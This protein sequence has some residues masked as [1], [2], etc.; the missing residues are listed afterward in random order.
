MGAVLSQEIAGGL[1]LSSIQYVPVGDGGFRCTIVASVNDESRHI[2]LVVM[3]VEKDSGPLLDGD[4]DFQ[5]NDALVANLL[6]FGV[7]EYAYR[8]G[9]HAD[10]RK[11]F[12]KAADRHSRAAVQLAE[13]VILGWYQTRLGWCSCCFERT[14]HRGVDGTFLPPVWLCGN[15]GAAT[16][17][18]FAAGCRHMARRPHGPIRVSPYCAE[19]R[20]E[21]R[22]FA[23][24]SERYRDLDA[25]D[26]LHKYDKKNLAGI[27]RT[28]LVAGAG[29]VVIGPIVFF[30]A[31][32]IGGALA[33]SGLIGP[34]LSGAAAT[35]H[36]LAVLGGGSIAAGGFGVA[37]GTVVVTATG[38]AL[39]GTLGAVTASAYLEDD[40]SFRIEKLKDG[41][42][43]PVVLAS[44]F[45]TE[46]GSGW[47]PWEPIITARYANNPVYRVHWG[48]KELKALGVAAGAIGGKAAAGVF[49]KG[50]AMHA[51][52][53]G[54]KLVPALGAATLA[55]DAIANPWHVARSRAEQT[56][57]VLADLLA[58]VDT[59][60]FILVGHSLG[61]R[62]ML[63]TAELLATK[64]GTPRLEA[65]HLLG[66]AV[67]TGGD[68]KLLNASVTERVWNYHSRKDSVLKIIYRTAQ[69]G[70]KAV[71]GVGF[72]TTFPRITDVN[73]SDDASSHSAYYETV[74][75]RAE[76]P[77]G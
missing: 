17:P 68:W 39:G 71:G 19:H 67:G 72:G 5:A 4:P 76:A 31:P 8:R 3:D 24:A 2:E 26:D 62:V 63:R 7:S 42:G 11:A 30:A 46:G 36:G 16:T 1:G 20:H 27:S 56:A 28:V 37:G 60:S 22:S 32:A 64:G 41:D 43:V 15:C 70:Q 44:G 18:C 75:L 21:I 47:G 50:A 38:A 29:A 65:V 54:A 59:P 10:Q 25:I 49:L 6:N 35:S 33:A 34:A 57:A 52:K 53:I 23:G 40:P 51:T 12:R 77:A 73:V 9:E 13:Y 14:E 74:V 66:A 61:G 58:R 69:A 48:A 55:S 45:L